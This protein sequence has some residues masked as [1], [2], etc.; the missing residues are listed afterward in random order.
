[1]TLLPLA[2]R[3]VSRCA[4]LS[5]VKGG[6][7]TGA[8]PP[9]GQHAGQQDHVKAIKEWPLHEHVIDGKLHKYNMFTAINLDNYPWE[10]CVWP[11][12]AH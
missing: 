2:C 6:G 12:A 11:Y 3:V 8:A 10:L 9:T 4:F 5:P 1:M 7:G